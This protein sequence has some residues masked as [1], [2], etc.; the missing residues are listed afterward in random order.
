LWQYLL[1]ASPTS[2]RTFEPHFAKQNP[3]SSAPSYF[4]DS[5]RSYSN[6]K[7]CC[8]LIVPTGGRA[9]Q[10]SRQ[11]RYR[12]RSPIY[13]DLSVPDD[14]ICFRHHRKIV[15]SR[16]STRISAPALAT[17]HRQRLL[18]E[19]Q[20]QIQTLLSALVRSSI[21]PRRILHSRSSMTG[22]KAPLKLSQPPLPSARPMSLDSALQ[23]LP[24]PRRSQHLRC[25]Q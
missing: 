12:G 6:V 10:D 5:S 15:S 2:L 3:S 18:T 19:I 17:R 25:F 11:A 24:K 21:P 1:S 13:Y 22:G 20:V 23:L 16:A 4:G 8:E 9:T 7:S 14:H